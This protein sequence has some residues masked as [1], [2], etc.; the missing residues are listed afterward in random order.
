[1]VAETPTLE[2][3]TVYVKY[4]SIDAFDDEIHFISHLQRYDCVSNG[5]GERDL[6]CRAVSVLEPVLWQLQSALSMLKDDANVFNGHQSIAFNVKVR[7]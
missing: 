5:S 1:M 4:N 3:L 2:R 6:A 7:F